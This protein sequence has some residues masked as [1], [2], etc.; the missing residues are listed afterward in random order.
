MP[1]A[2]VLD[3]IGVRV[4]ELLS[5]ERLR[6][7]VAAVIATGWFADATVRVEP[8][9]DGVRVAFIVVENPEITGIIVEGNTAIPTPELI[10]AMDVPL[11]QVLNI[12]RLRDGA[13]KIEK[14]YE[15]RGYVL[16]RVVDI[17]VITDGGVR[18][19]LR[20]SEGKV[21]A[22]E[23]KG[24]VKTQRYVLDRGA[25]VKPNVIFNINDL[26]KDLQRLFDLGLFDNVQARPRPGSTP[27]A[28]VVEIEVKEQRTQQ[29]RFGLG[30][31][32]R[33][34]IVGL[35]EYSERNWKGRNQQVTVRYERGLGERN[36]PT[37][38]AL[39]PSNFSLSFREPFLDSRN[40]AMEITLYRSTTGEV[41]YPFGSSVPDSRFNLERLGSFI[42][43]TRAIDPVTAIT[44]RLRSERAAITPT[45]LDLTVAPCNTNPDDPACPKPAPTSFLPGRTIGLTLVGVRDRRDNRLTP[46]K[47]EKIQLVADFGLPVLGGDFGFGKY[48]AEYTKY[49]PLGTSVLV[50]HVLLGASHGTLPAQDQFYLGGTSTIRA[51]PY[52]RFRGN[53][54]ALFNLEYRTPLGFLAR[55]LKEFTGIVYVDVGSAPITTNT[56]YGAGFAI[57]V[58]T[59]VGPIR[60]DYAIGPEGRQTWLTIGQPF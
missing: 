16:A 13:R 53:T 31:S 26:N 36:V 19:R 15:E 4:G 39:A 7:D 20:V 50:G 56:G 10:R 48:N 18:L 57:S 6:A 5:D 52:G 59:P 37:T 27:E 22:I 29:A 43:F 35:L 17:G 3:S 45:A 11:N 54:M 44:L 14:L 25:R 47:G 49:F 34:G 40:T 41:E 1:E 21:E 32:D 8:A 12:V 33:T 9:R 51:Y 55:Q 38:S 28:V 60:I 30:Y 23:Y 58:T 2:V 24:L 46:T 42:A